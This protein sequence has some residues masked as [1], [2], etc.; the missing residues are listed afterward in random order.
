MGCG[1]STVAYKSTQ[2]PGDLILSNVEHCHSATAPVPM[3]DGQVPADDLALIPKEKTT[4]SPVVRPADDQGL[5]ADGE[6][7][8][9]S[10]QAAHRGHSARVKSNKKKTSS[11]ISAAFIA[12]SALDSKPTRPGTRNAKNTMNTSVKQFQ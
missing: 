3:A 9:T 2:G 5:K 12:W 11:V 7:A 8:A 1:A 10:I 4:I 6:V